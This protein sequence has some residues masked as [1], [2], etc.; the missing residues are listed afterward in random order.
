M[1]GVGTGWARQ[2]YAA[3][4]V[5]F[6]RRGAL[7]DA[8]LATILE[9]WRDRADYRAG[10]IPLWIGGNTGAGMRRAV[11]F[12]GVW[13]PLRF[14]LAWFLDAVGRLA[15]IAAD[16]GRPTPALAPRIVLRLTDTPLADSPLAGPDRRAGEG[17]LEQVLD[18]L[19][20]LEK[21]GAASVVLDPYDGDTSTAATEEALRALRLV[22][23]S[24]KGLTG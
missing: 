23:H 8:Y 3:L 12:G 4:G 5:P 7:T 17:T 10:E 14:T 24:R 20:R 18:D 9:A 2:E 16:A 15:G 13:H 6:E 21:A 1:L 22:A 11:R 19:D